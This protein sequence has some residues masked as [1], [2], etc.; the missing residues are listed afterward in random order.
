V[1]S[2]FIG[3]TIVLL[4]NVV[5]WRIKIFNLICYILAQQDAFPEDNRTWFNYDST[6]NGAL[7]HDI[8]LGAFASHLYN[9]PP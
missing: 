2:K 7:G 3:L 6:Q 4:E 9:L 1:Y 8:E 5:L